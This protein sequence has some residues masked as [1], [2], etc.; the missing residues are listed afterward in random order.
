MGERLM[1]HTTITNRRHGPEIILAWYMS[2][3]SIIFF[4]RACIGSAA[5]YIYKSIWNI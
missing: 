4:P 5:E 2:N 3:G 1:I